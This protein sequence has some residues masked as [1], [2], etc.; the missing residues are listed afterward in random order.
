M[1]STK[2]VA[3][4]AARR[5]LTRRVLVAAPVEQAYGRAAIEAIIGYARRHTDWE[6]LFAPKP[7]QPEGVDRF[8]RGIDG[9]IADGNVPRVLERLRFN[10]APMVLM[11]GQRRPGGAGWVMIDNEA[12]GRLAASYLA[13]LGFRRFGFCGM[14]DRWASGV[15]GAAFGAAVA[16]MDPPGALHEFETTPGQDHDWDAEAPELIEWVRNLPKPIAV[17]ATHDDRGRL[18]ALACQ[19]AGV[20][21]PEQV[22]ILG[23][24]N[25]ELTC[26]MAHPPLSSIDH[27][28]RRMGREAAAMLHRMLDGQAAPE[29]PVVIKPVGVVNRRSTDILSIE[30]PMLARAV[31]MIRER[32]TEGLTVSDLLSALPIGRRTLELAFRKTLGR[33]PHKEILRVRLDHARYLLRSSS[34]DLPTITSRCGFKYASQFS[35]LFRKHA[36]ESPSAYRARHET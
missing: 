24:N 35:A 33:T 9:V 19:E 7:S 32:A 27:N 16:G 21:V 34:L 5:G 6:L 10:A 26:E 31:R 28:A 14:P 20:A 17:F 15:R 11:S 8:G 29:Q 13:G 25:D 18:V 30:D 1:G 22:A 12:V 3:P 23:V 2:D 4:A 36:G